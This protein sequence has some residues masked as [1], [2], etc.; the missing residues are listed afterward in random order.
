VIGLPL[1]KWRD[2]VGLVVTNINNHKA[3]Q[4]RRLQLLKEFFTRTTAHVPDLP[5]FFKFNVGDTVNVDLSTLKRKDLGFKYSLY[6]GKPSQP[7]Q[8]GN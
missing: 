2:V 1:S 3:P 6:V 5:Q 4:K 8:E 7:Q